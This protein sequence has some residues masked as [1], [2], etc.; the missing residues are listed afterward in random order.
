MDDLTA[1]EDSLWLFEEEPTVRDSKGNDGAEFKP[2]PRLPIELRLKIL[3]LLD[4]RFLFNKEIDF[5][6]LYSCTR[7]ICSTLTSTHLR[8]V[9]RLTVATCFHWNWAHNF[10]DGWDLYWFKESYGAHSRPEHRTIGTL[11]HYFKARYLPDLVHLKLEQHDGPGFELGALAN[12][13]EDL[14]DSIRPLFF[15]YKEGAGGVEIIP[16]VE[17]DI[18][19]ETYPPRYKRI[20]SMLKGFEIFFL[21]PG[22]TSCLLAE[23]AAKHQV[24]LETVGITLWDVF[25]PHYFMDKDGINGYATDRQADYFR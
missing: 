23:P 11:L 7:R 2:F 5:L 12:V 20:L 16:L 6:R 13:R 19:P 10:N 24:W 15:R 4:L 3:R 9:Q 22:E 8:G 21:G 25:A 14:R 1:F 18:I 17:A